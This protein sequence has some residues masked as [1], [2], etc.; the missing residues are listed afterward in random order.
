MIDNFGILER[1]YRFHDVRRNWRKRERERG[2][3]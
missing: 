1:R 3:L 2:R